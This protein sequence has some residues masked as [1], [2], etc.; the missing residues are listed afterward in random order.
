M[1]VEAILK[2]FVDLLLPLVNSFSDVPVTFPA[3][4]QPV[5]PFISGFAFVFLPGV[6]IVIIWRVVAYFL[7]GGAG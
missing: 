3:I 5:E 2:F 6:V 7:P 4:P 1:I